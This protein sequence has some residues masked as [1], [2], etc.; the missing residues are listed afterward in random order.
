MM[1]SHLDLDDLNTLE[2]R[3]RGHL[4]NSLSGFKSANLVGTKSS[5]G[6]TNL[7]I[8]SSA[9]HLGAD[10]A[11]MGFIIR[12]DESPRHT[13]DN[14]RENTYL[15]INHVNIDIIEQAHQSSAR[16]PRETSEFMACGLNEEYAHE[17]FAPYVKEAHIKM[18]LQMISERVLEENGTHL[19]VA[20]IMHIYFPKEAWDNEGPLDLN[21]ANSIAVSG[22]DTYHA[23]KKI[24]R[25]SYAKTDKVLT[26][27]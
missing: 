18:G 19:I 4:V 12:P 16:Y 21:L 17:F 1:T 22:L 24:K 3:T 20:K 26:E 9:F 11:L 23:G 10:P 13:L 15:T 25:L 6:Q 14:M 2:K 27:I 5:D 7:S 8:I